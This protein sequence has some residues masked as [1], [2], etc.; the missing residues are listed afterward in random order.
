MH[1]SP[2]S[3]PTPVRILSRA[4]VRQL[5]DLRQC[6]DAV[7]D[8]FRRHALGR[9]IPPAVLAA[10]V[11]GGGF[12]VKTA[13]M[14]G[15]AKRP[16]SMFA[17]K[18][19]ANFPANPTTSGLPTIQGVIALF[20]ATDGQVLALLDSTEIT[21]VRTAAAT[22]VAAKYLAHTAASVVT[23]CGCGEQSKSQLRAL[24]C[25]RPLRRVM[26]YDVEADRA[27]SFAR[28]MTAELGLDIVAVRELGDAT[29][30]SDIWVTCTTARHWFLG[31]RHVASGAFVA[32]V[33][34]DNPEKQEIEPELLAENVV[35]ADVLE[36]CAAIGDL[37]HALDGGVMQRHD[38]RAELAEIVTGRI[39]GRRSD[40]EIIVFDSTGTALQ[41]VAVA[42]LVYDRAL[43]SAAGLTIDLGGASPT[44]T[45]ATLGIT[46]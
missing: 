34:A 38:V 15:D 2:P 35:V 17:A 45:E 18:I 10:H 37:H 36:Q 40:A 6:I 26:A 27:S 1:P 24:A 19:N 41:D 32:A 28:E 11:D 33:G 20:D 30:S 44:P 3:T 46:S 25:V 23:V 4:D 21:S 13:G 16:R 29:A 7:E 43:A 42:A 31:R 22:A 39:I 9:S 8:A 5:I 12:H 14:L